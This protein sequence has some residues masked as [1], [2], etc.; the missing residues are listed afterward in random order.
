MFGL[1]KENLI[2]IFAVKYKKKVPSS[3]SKPD[4]PRTKHERLNEVSK[5]WVL[6]KLR[7]LEI[8]KKI[9]KVMNILMIFLNIV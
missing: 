9:V 6:I 1:K 5:K 8:E 4:D 7:Y 2:S 3:R